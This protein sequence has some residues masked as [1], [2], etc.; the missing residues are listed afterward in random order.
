MN[1]R[2]VIHRSACSWERHTEVAFATQVSPHWNER[3][4]FA[5]VHIIVLDPQHFGPAVRTILLAVLAD[6][7]LWR[8]LCLQS[9][10]A[11]ITTFL[12][13]ILCTSLHGTSSKRPRGLSTT[14]L[15]QTTIEKNHPTWIAPL[16]SQNCYRRHNLL[17]DTISFASIHLYACQK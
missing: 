10:L 3:L 6:V 5:S 11:P 8:S 14:H 4:V 12:Q 7:V 9:L 1:I 17:G 16:G 13:L 15:S 2:W